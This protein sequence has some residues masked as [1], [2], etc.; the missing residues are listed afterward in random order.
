MNSHTTPDRPA[1]SED[2]KALLKLLDTLGSEGAIRSLLHGGTV[3]THLAWL[4]QQP[5]KPTPTRR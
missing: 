5:P 1:L 3:S 2:D 4:K